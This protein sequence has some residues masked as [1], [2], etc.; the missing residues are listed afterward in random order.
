MELLLQLPP[1]QPP[2]RCQRGPIVTPDLIA[3]VIT[4]ICPHTISN[5]PIVLMPKSQI[6]IVYVSELQPIEVTYD[7]FSNFQMKKAKNFI[8]AFPKINFAL[9]ACRRMIS[10][11]H[12]VLNLIGQEN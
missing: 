12:Y 9:S 6:R 10:I 7:G 8:F 5:R 11:P 4:P 3:F 1:G 2:I